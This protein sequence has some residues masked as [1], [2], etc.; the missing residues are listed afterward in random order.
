M[1]EKQ[2]IENITEVVNNEMDRVDKIY[3]LHEAMGEINLWNG[4]FEESL[5]YD[6]DYF[7][8]FHS[9][10]MMTPLQVISSIDLLAFNVNDDYFVVNAYGT[11]SLKEIELADYLEDYADEIIENFVDTLHGLEWEDFTPEV[12]KALIKEYKESEGK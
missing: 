9:I 7:D 5:P 3:F 6:M 12:I 1:T 2:L 8:E 11:Y 10:E 4:A